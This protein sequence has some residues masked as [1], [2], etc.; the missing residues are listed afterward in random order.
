MADLPSRTSSASTVNPESMQRHPAPYVDRPEDIT[1]AIEVK[2]IFPLLCPNATDPAPHDPRPIQRIQDPSNELVCSELANALVAR[3]IRNAGAQAVTSE[4]IK[5][6]GKRERDFWDSHWIVK[7]A[8][9]PEPREDELAIEEYAWVSVEIISH[10]YLLKDADTLDRVKHVLTALRSNHRIVANYTCDTHV[11]IGRH[12]NQAFTLQTLQRLAT[13]VWPAEQTL[14]SIRDPR[15]KNYYNIFTWGF[16]T[17]LSRLGVMVSGLDGAAANL[18]LTEEDLGIPDHQIVRAIT[19]TKSLPARE[20]KVFQEI[21]KTDSHKKLGKL[22]SG[23]HRRYRRLGLNFSMFGLEDDRSRI[24]PRTMEFRFMDGTLDSSL[25]VNWMSICGRIIEAVISNEDGCYEA[26]LRGVLQRCGNGT[27][28]I[29]TGDL[30]GAQFGREFR[31]LMEDLCVP[32]ETYR[33]FEDKVRKENYWVPGERPSDPFKGLGWDIAEDSEEEE[34]V[35]Q[36]ISSPAMHLPLQPMS[37]NRTSLPAHPS[38]R[39]PIK[40]RG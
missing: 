19:A 31:E 6:T 2:Y 22:L 15:S 39:Q 33:Q 18:A 1:V 38:L 5:S 40:I 11:H 10:K 16:E 29:P 34:N 37:R 3:T 36:E 26:A 32:R 25:A 14:R 28:A 9:S 12:D 8:G 35:P 13:L 27:S 21:W 7:K 24:N 20:L 23:K 4:V 30:R 17:P